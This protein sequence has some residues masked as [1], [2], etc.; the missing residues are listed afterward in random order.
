MPIDNEPTASTSSPAGLTGSSSFAD[1]FVQVIPSNTIRQQFT[2]QHALVD[3]LDNGYD[4]ILI[5][6][7]FLIPPLNIKN[8]II[9]AGRRGVAVRIICGGKSD[10]PFMRWSSNHIYHKFLE[11]PSI[12]IFE[13]QPRILH[14][15]TITIDGLYSSIGSFNLDFLSSHKLLEVNVGMV[16]NEVAR[17]L[18]KQHDEDI[19]HCCEITK[20]SLKKRSLPERL[21]HFLAYHITRIVHASML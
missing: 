21:L 10:T 16:S 8:A 12:R 7:P 15:K 4:Y 6:N 9:D 13:Y 18:E 3:V 5:T 1:V 17:A 19:K 20:A 11:Y 2:I 14:A